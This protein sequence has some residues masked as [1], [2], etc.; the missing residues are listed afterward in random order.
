MIRLSFITRL[1]ISV[2]FYKRFGKSF[3]VQTL[4]KIAKMIRFSKK[5]ARLL[6]LTEYLFRDVTQIDDVINLFSDILFL[7]EI[8]IETLKTFLK[9]KICHHLL[10]GLPWGYTLFEILKIS[11]TL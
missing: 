1:N 7:F 10:P 9:T 11:M 3:L 5:V 2:F 4:Y 6:A 8:R